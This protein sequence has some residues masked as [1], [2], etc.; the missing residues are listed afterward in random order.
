MNKK[1]QEALIILQEECAEVIQAASKCFRFGI[2]NE[3][4]AGTTQRSN[5]EMEIGDMLALVDILVEQG[6][7]DLNNLNIA[8]I[9][10][11]EKLKVWSNL[12]EQD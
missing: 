6:V 11:I 8:K 2:D 1:N 4:K 10:K 9:N 3:H 5:L 7:V 12:Y